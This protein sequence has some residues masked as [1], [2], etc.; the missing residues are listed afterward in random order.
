[1]KASDASPRPWRTLI[2][3]PKVRHPMAMIATAEDTACI[4]CTG[5]GNTYRQDC[6]NAALIVRAVNA[7]DAHDRLVEAARDALAVNCYSDG[8]AIRDCDIDWT[9]ALRAALRECEESER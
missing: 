1:M 5:S 4:D 6:A 9:R 8:T 2:D 3:N 7:I